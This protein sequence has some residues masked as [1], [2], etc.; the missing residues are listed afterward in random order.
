[1]PLA[2]FFAARWKALAEAYGLTVR[3]I[4]YQWGTRIRPDDVA[5]RW[6][7]D[8]AKAVLLTQSE[9]STGVIQPIRE[10]AA[11]AR[12]AGALVV[13]R[14]RVAV[15][16]R[17]RSSSTRGASTWRS[18][19][20]RRRSRRA[21]ASPSWRSPIAPRA[22]AETATNPRFYFD[23][24]IYKTFARPAEPREPVDPGDQ[25]GAGARGRAPA[26]LPGRGRG[27]AR[28]AI[29]CC[30]RAVKEGVR[31]LG[32]DLFG[33]GLDDNWTVTAIRAPDGI[34]ADTHQ[35]PDPGRLRLR[36]GPRPGAAQG[37]G[38]PHRPLRV[39]Q[40]ARHHPRA[41]GA[42]DD[43]RAARAP[44]EARRGGRPRPSRCSWSGLR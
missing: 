15:S 30:R 9:T 2:G 6:P 4:E 8:P 29:A 33:E 10:L 40:R 3:T 21:P 41:R 37:D 5:A 12:E 44:G 13:R 31:A 36:A 42:R 43:A 38:V 1:M 23:W 16:A 19:D 34:D 27:G 32:L 17:C 11:V 18:A 35:R 28:T 26:V 39:L 25:R 22:A 20:R 14:R 7:S 24:R